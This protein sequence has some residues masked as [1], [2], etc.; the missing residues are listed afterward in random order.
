MKK[1]LILLSLLGLSVG[2]TYGLTVDQSIENAVSY[3]KKM[4]F[5]TDG[6]ENGDVKVVIDGTN[7][8]VSLSGFL[9]ISEWALKDGTVVTADLK[10]GAVTSE[11]IADGSIKLEDLDPDLELWVFKKI[12]TNAVYTDGNVW[13]GTTSPGAKLE[14][15]GNI[16]WRDS[17]Q[18]NLR[19]TWAALWASG[20]WRPWLSVYDSSDFWWITTLDR[21]GNLD[22]IDDVDTLIYWWD[23]SSDKLRFWYYEWN[24]T[25]TTLSTKMVLLANGNLGIGV[26]N[27][28]SKLQVEWDIK[29][30]TY[31]GGKIIVR[32]VSDWEGNSPRIYFDDK[33]TTSVFA[34]DGYQW[35]FRIFRE[36]SIGVD[37]DTYFVVDSNGNVGIWESQ[38]QEKL[39]VSGRLQ[40]TTDYGDKI[41][42]GWDNYADDSEVYINAPEERNKVVFW[43]RT[44]QKRANI[45]AAQ[46]RFSSWLYTKWA[47]VDFTT[48]E[49]QDIEFAHVDSE[50]NIISRDFKIDA[51]GRVFIWTDEVKQKVNIWWWMYLKNSWEKVLIWTD[52]YN[53]NIELRDEDSSDAWN[54]PYIDFSN[55]SE[56]DYD[57]R[58]RLIDDDKLAIEW[59]NVGIGTTNPQAKLDVNGSV[60]IRWKYSVRRDCSTTIYMIDLKWNKYS[61]NI[62]GLD[63]GNWH[64]S[65]WN[66]ICYN[67]HGSS[68]DAELQFNITDSPSISCTLLHSEDD[69]PS[70]SKW[71]YFSTDGWNNCHVYTNNGSC[72]NVKKAGATTSPFRECWAY[73]VVCF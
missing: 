15:Y 12:W 55:D 36:P 18:I 5:T 71:I 42:L 4:I 19:Y 72:F 40:A 54:T 22:T 20:L 30:G 66:K 38:P 27:P 53:P 67:S 34:I 44:L 2:L 37:G 17:M 23:N 73:K 9:N 6:T 50:W 25:N 14:V 26:T 35:K 41:W 21:D 16:K 57:A 10:D 46:W 61:L 29:A 68:D 3:I 33:N 69:D 11:K 62:N 1:N 63:D 39:D 70:Y 51:N 47:D 49:G 65:A 32:W 56:V 8:N 7:G 64:C 52:V 31:D 28:Q 58:I 45:K 59:T 60:I 24:G 43:N 13:I 48:L